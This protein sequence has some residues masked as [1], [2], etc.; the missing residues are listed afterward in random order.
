[1]IGFFR[2][3]A[4]QVLTPFLH[5]VHNV[6]FDTNSFIEIIHVYKYIYIYTYTT[7]SSVRVDADNRSKNVKKQNKN[8]TS[9]NYDVLAL[10]SR[11]FIQT[12]WGGGGLV[13]FAVK[14]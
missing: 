3:G 9:A 12:Q 5:T 14:K 4:P 8:E 1:M 7:L 10:P 6:E 11:G 2:F 13:D